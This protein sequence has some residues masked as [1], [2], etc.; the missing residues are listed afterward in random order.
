[1]PVLQCQYCNIFQANE[2]ALVRHQAHA[3]ACRKKRDEYITTTL[4]IR[5]RRHHRSPTSAHA[6]ALPVDPINTPMAAD[7]FMDVDMRP[8]VMIATD[9]EMLDVD[10]RDPD[11]P[12]PAPPADDDDDLGDIFEEAFPP[13]R[14]AGATYG[15]DRIRTY[16][17]RPD[18]D[19]V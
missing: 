3:P 8:E 7:D 5:R 10:A 1:M 13:D 9:A 15:E 16:P 19:R 17:R 18:L 11:L 2:S 6:P 12:Q 14:K 4:L